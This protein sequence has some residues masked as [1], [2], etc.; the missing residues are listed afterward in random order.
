MR[1]RPDC[2][3]VG[4]SPAIQKT[5][6]FDVFNQGEV[7]RSLHYHTDAAGKCVN[8]CRVLTQGG[9]DASCLTVAGRE[10]RG[11]FEALCKRDSLELVTVETSGR[12]RICTTIVEMANNRTSEIVANE[13]EIITSEEEISFRSTFLELLSNGFRSVLI[14]GSK[15]PGFS[16]E[17]IPFMVKEIKNFKVLLFADYRGVDLKNS[18]ISEEIRPDYIKINEEEFF[19]TFG[20]F[21]SLEEGLKEISS[22]YKSVFVISR[23]ALSTLV[24]DEGQLFEVESEMIKAVNPIGCGDSMT[25]G[26]AQGILEGLSLKEAV[27]LGRDY[28]TRN[29]LSI[30]PGWILEKNNG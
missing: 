4:L 18:F 10:N 15:F 19:E 3:A 6:I 28:A 12:V 26:L 13:P 11:E 27:E 16:D 7:N 22:K 5:L 25:A 21:S 20:F 8:V 23:G 1:N 24:A 17:I 30:H 29:A 2:L 9:M 14:S